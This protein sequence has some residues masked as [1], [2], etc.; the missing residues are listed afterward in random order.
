MK[1][2]TLIFVLILISINLQ[3]QTYLDALYILDSDAYTEGEGGERVL[4]LDDMDE[5][6]LEIL[7]L[8]SGDN[9][10]DASDVEAAFVGNPFF[11]V[12]R[13]GHSVGDEISG[14]GFSAFGKSRPTPTSPPSGSPLSVAT[15]ADGLAKFLVKRTKQELNEAFFRK[16]QEKLSDE[17]VRLDVLFPETESTLTLI[18]T[19]IYQFN[20]FVSTLRAAFIQD[21]TTINYNAENWF[22]L[23][24]IRNLFKTDKKYI[25]PILADVFQ[26]SGMIENGK[27]A[28]DLLYYLAYDAR[29]PLDDSWTEGQKENL[30]TLT[31][32]FQFTQKISFSLKK[33]YEKNTWLETQD[34]MYMKQN[35]KLANIFAGLAYQNIK[36]ILYK[37]DSTLGDFINQ[38]NASEFLNYIQDIFYYYKK[39]DDLQFQIKQSITSEMNS[40]RVLADTK[41]EH[42]WILY[43]QYILETFDLIDETINELTIWGIIDDAQEG[44]LRNYLQAAIDGSNM[45]MSIV[46]GEYGLAILELA[47]FIGENVNEDNQV[48]PFLVKYGSFMVSAAEAKDSDEVAAAIEAFALPPGSSSIKKYSKFNVSLNAFVGAA[49]GVEFLSLDNDWSSLEAKGFA[50]FSSPVGVTTSWG[51]N[52]KNNS[53][54]GF[55]VPLIDIGALTTFRFKDSEAELLPDFK[56][57]NILAPGAYIM[58]HIGHDLPLSFGFGGQFGPNLRKV[59]ETGQPVID[60][61]GFRLGATFSVDIPIFNLYT[62]PRDRN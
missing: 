56:F 8:Y 29:F 15:L 39:L 6:M 38:S 2:I 17:R 20:A 24:E 19:D 57:K 3:S 50:A 43:N 13:G 34:I 23:P 61:Q 32:A 7:A 31:A 9:V 16:F 14:G 47:D 62:N 35:P 59:E 37:N 49:G 27:N 51:L 55:F 60:A 22:S 40:A 52:N 58:Y 42:K 25:I 21:L 33:N 46:K 12:V 41:Q 10:S 45:G 11:Q 4:V 28:D 30:V 36:D 53:A 48:V 44:E 54:F 26:L 1:N 5:N 18:G